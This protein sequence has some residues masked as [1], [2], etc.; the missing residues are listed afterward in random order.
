MSASQSLEV[1]NLVFSFGERFP[2]LID[3]ETGIPDFDVTLYVLTQLRARNLSSSTLTAA[4]RSVMFGYQVLEH[5]GIDFQERIDNG[6]LFDLGGAR[7]LSGQLLV[8]S[9]KAP[10]GFGQIGYGID[11]EARI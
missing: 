6:K 8:D 7:S 4:I 10:T 2:A 9:K 11:S 5:M 3:R 1:R